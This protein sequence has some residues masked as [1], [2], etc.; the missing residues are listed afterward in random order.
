[1]APYIMRNSFQQDDGDEY[2][3]SPRRF[4]A[5]AVTS[6]TVPARSP[7]SSP[8]PRSPVSRRPPRTPN[9]R[10]LTMASLSPGPLRKRLSDALMSPRRN[11]SNHNRTSSKQDLPPK[12]KSNI[13]GGRGR[14]SSASTKST[15]RNSEYNDYVEDYNDGREYEDEDSDNDD[16]G[17][18]DILKSPKLTKDI[19][20]KKR[21]KQRRSAGRNKVDGNDGSRV[22]GAFSPVETVRKL[23]QQLV[24]SSSTHSRRKR[25]DSDDDESCDGDDIDR[26]CD[27][28]D[29]L[30]DEDVMVLLC[31]EL[32]LMDDDDDE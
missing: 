21:V 11:S 32:Q 24:R 4:S 7:P 22:V 31:R 16:D 18:S 2:L 1:M 12:V 5:T 8:P 28:N 17:L 9:N 23:S 3:T 6:T 27:S 20:K 26:S 19:M 15:A 30:E 25:Y 10:S 29:L 13:F 14:K